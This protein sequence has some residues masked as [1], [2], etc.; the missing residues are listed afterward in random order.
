[1]TLKYAW[2]IVLG[3]A[4]QAMLDPHDICG[5]PDLQREYDDQGEAIDLVEQF[6]TDELAAR[7]DALGIVDAPET[8]Q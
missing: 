4:E 6:V 1:M 5:D 2:K 3:L 7:M 8:S